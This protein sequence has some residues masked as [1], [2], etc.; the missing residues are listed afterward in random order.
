MLKE[1]I[2]ARVEAVPESGCWI[3]TKCLTST[4]YGQVTRNNKRA[5][6]HRLAWEVWNGKITNGLHV[7]HRCDVRCC[8]NPAHLFLGTNLDNIADAVK[9]GRKKGPRNRPSGLIYSPM[10]AV[11]KINHMK[12]KPEARKMLRAD[13]ATGFFSERALAKKYGCS[14]GCA[15]RIIK[16]VIS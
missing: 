4:G 14:A 7:L 3:W 6:V 9:K 12:V 16:E 5:Q 15:H 13:Y 2:E 1:Y 8:V 10:S 11:G